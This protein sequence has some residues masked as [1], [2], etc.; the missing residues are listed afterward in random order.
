[1]EL[2]KVRSFLRLDARLGD[3]AALLDVNAL[4]L[5]ENPFRRRGPGWQP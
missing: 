3:I 5:L 2:P 4:D 1:M